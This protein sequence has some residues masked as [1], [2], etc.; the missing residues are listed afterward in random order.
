MRCPLQ[1]TALQKKIKKYKKIQKTQARACMRSR[2]A[3][4]CAWCVVP[5]TPYVLPPSVFLYRKRKK[6]QQPHALDALC[7]LLRMPSHLLYIF[8]LYIIYVWWAFAW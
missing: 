1:K 7:R 4:A 3:T 6:T 2:T 8:I 5:T